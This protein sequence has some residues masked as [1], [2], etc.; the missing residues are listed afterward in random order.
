VAARGPHA[1]RR[2]RRMDPRVIACE[3]QQ[4]G[5][6]GLSPSSFPARTGSGSP[7]HLQSNPT[8][9][10][11]RFHFCFPFFLLDLPLLVAVW[12]VEDGRRSC[13]GWLRVCGGGRRY[14]R[15]RFG[16]RWLACGGWEVSVEAGLADGLHSCW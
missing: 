11:S 5:G 9:T 10:S 13:R 8:N 15:R 3:D 12:M 7:S 6:S 2:W 1:H 4:T 14:G 16:V